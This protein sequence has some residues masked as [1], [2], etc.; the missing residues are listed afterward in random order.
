M[1]LKHKESIKNIEKAL[2][3]NKKK[4][5]MKVA[6]YLGHKTHPSLG[7]KKSV[8]KAENGGKE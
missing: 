1:H 3:K 6:L 4:V 5:G 8:E 7:M 2:R